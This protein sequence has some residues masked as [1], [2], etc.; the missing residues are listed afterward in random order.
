MVAMV[1]E[2]TCGLFVQKPFAALLMN[3]ADRRSRGRFQ[4]TAATD[5]DLR[6]RSGAM[7]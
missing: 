6:N 2:M 3:T 1:S 4:V 5:H 7:E